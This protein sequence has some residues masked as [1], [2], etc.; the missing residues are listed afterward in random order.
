M[1]LRQQGRAGE[2]QDRAQHDGAEDADHQHPL[3]LL[4]GHREVGHQHQEHEDVVDRQRLLDQV[5]GEELQAHAVGFGEPGGLVHVPPQG[6]VEQ[7]RQG[8]PAQAPPHRFLER[9]L[10]RAAVAH[11]HQVD[12]QG[13]HDQ[14]AEPGP[15]PGI[16][17]RVHR[18]SRDQVEDGRGRGGLGHRWTGNRGHAFASAAKVLL[19][20]RW[21]AVGPERDRS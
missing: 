16:A 21:A 17:Y 14:P 20:A 11:Q 9:D 8:D 2:D 3:A 13:G 4:L 7:Q 10:V 1:E 19:T 15:Q 6:A 5:A 12:Q 18:D